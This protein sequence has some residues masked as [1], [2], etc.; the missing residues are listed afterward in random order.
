MANDLM[1]W[2]RGLFPQ[3]GGKT[4]FVFLVGAVIPGFSV[5]GIPHDPV[6]WVEV[7]PKEQDGAPM[8]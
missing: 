6:R 8:A 4:V 3:P 1:Q 2:S 5:H 7:N